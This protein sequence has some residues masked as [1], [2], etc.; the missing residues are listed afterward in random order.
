MF[1]CVNRLQSTILNKTILTN[2]RIQQLA[3]CTIAA[4]LNY[5]NATSFS[6]FFKLLP[7]SF[8]IFISVEQIITI[9][10]CDFSINAHS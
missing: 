3:N 6:K 4:W 9:R 7:L 2:A 1:F 10:F 5:N 8:D